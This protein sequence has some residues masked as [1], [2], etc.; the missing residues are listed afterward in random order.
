MVLGRVSEAEQ[1]ASSKTV[2]ANGKAR[3]L[4]YREQETEPGNVLNCAAI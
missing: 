1:T 2:A 3:V 4:E